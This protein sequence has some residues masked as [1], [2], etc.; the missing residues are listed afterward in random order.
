MIKYV[1][2]FLLDPIDTA[3]E[4]VWYE[5]YQHVCSSFM[6]LLIVC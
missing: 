3:G 4:E 2:E 1:N 6:Q 5:M